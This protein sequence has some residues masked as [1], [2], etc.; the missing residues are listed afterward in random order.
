VSKRQSKKANIELPPAAFSNA[1]NDLD[2][3]F[4]FREWRK[5]KYWRVFVA[6]YNEAVREA[7][8][9]IQSRY[10]LGE[11]AERIFGGRERWKQ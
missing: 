11:N 10:N 5:S 7:N 1:M 8:R 4:D 2:S 9:Q 6:G 3:D